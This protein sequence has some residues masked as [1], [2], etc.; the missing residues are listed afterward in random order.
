MS[1]QSR[2]LVLCNPE[3]PEARA[4]MESV[5]ACISREALVV[6]SGAVTENKEWLGRN[7]DRI[8]VLGGDGSILAVARELQDRQVPIIGVNFGKLGFLAEFSFEELQNNAGRILTDSALVSRRMMLTTEVARNGQGYGDSLAVNDCVVHAGP[9]FRMIELSIAVNG[10]YL[11]SVSGDGLVLAT[12][13]GSTAQNMSAGGPILAP[14]ARAIVVSPISPHSLTHRP[15]VVAADAVIE[16]LAR[17]VNEGTTAVIDGQI[18]FPLGPGDRLTVRQAAYDFQL[19][20]NPGQ[21]Q[22]HTLTQ[23]LKWG[24]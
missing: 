12:P 16:V 3:K 2:V 23:K 9:P 14:G 17:R 20:R 1:K 21:A 19:V 8:I 4:A 22:W 6:A 7:P 5:I 10:E 24:Q 11:T 15:L 18:S 13:T